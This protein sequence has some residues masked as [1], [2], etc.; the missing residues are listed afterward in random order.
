MMKI[1]IVDDSKMQRH[2]LQ[3]IL[4]NLGFID[5]VSADS[6]IQAKRELITQNFGLILSDMHMPEED[7]L[8]LLKFVKAMPKLSTIPF[9]MITGDS[10]KQLVIKSVKSGISD[11]I[12]KPV[13]KEILA[14]KMINLGIDMPRH[15]E[16]SESATNISFLDVNDLVESNPLHRIIQN[17]ETLPKEIRDQIIDLVDSSV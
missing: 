4:K 17:W 10:D 7:G 12:S 5:I 3:L 13:D 9:I 16:E 2:C 14:Q 11:Y 6:V 8:A 1:L 15:K